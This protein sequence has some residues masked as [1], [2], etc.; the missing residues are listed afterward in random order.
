MCRIVE[1]DLNGAQII[2]FVLINTHMATCTL[3]E[4][5][6]AVII[7]FFNTVHDTVHDAHDT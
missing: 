5:V 6:V 2:C 7:S 3:K 1:G 4:L